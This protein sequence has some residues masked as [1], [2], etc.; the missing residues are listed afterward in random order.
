MYVKCYNKQIVI[1]VIIKN[2]LGTSGAN[3]NIPY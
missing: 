2:N 1:S 3:K